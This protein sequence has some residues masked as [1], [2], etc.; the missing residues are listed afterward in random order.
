MN[1][2]AT[3]YTQPSSAVIDTSAD[4][5]DMVGVFVGDELRGVANVSH[6]SELESLSN[7]H[8]YEVF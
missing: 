1:M 6:L 2:V 8:P 4:I 7:F 3:L 5:Y